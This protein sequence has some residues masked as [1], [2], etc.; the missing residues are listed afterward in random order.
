MLIEPSPEVDELA[1]EVLGAAIAVHKALGPGFLE[2]IY[3]RALTI[4][5]R[6]RK[7]SFSQQV[8]QSIVYR[9]EVVGEHRLDLLVGGRLIVELKAVESLTNQHLA[10]ML[11][12]L[13]ATKL[14]LGLI[15]N[16]RAAVLR[17]GIR[18]VVTRQADRERI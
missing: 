4:E 5:L 9:D 15:L 2:S 16:F 13:R 7:I 8:I 11:S 14:E 12:Y 6:H 10:Q 17:E 3:E 1:H 18:R